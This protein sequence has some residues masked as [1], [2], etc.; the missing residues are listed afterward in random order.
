[1]IFRAFCEGSRSQITWGLQEPRM[2]FVRRP[3]EHAKVS[4]L[5]DPA[6]SSIKRLVELSL[7][8]YRS[9]ACIPFR[10]AQAAGKLSRRESL[11]NDE[12]QEMLFILTKS[13]RLSRF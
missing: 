3:L 7:N 2:S 12:A 5:S 10:Q 8:D 1:M 11:P 9:H 13:K 6:F 4:L